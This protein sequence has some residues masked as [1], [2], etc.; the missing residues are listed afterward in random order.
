MHAIAEDLRYAA[1]S[2]TKRP[3]YA[4]VTITVLALAIGANTTVFSVFN[5][6]FLRPLPYPDGDRLVSVYNTYPGLG[7][8]IAGTSIP[9]YL[10]RRAEAPSL[11]DLAIV[12]RSARS[13]TGEGPAEQIAVAMA[14]PSLFSVL[15][16]APELGRS[17]SDDEAVPG[18]D[19]VAVLS[20]ALWLSRFGA[21]ANV[22][23]QSIRLDGRP[24]RIVG[25]MPPA[26]GYPDR[27][28]GVWVPFAF[29]PEQMSDAER[30][31]EFSTSVG[32][33]APGA[34]VAGL[35]AE[36]AAIVRRTN[37]RLRER[38]PF[39][40]S[41]GFTGRS[42]LL[43]D[44]IVGDLETMLLVLEGIVLAVLLIASANVTNLQLARMASRRKELS[45]RAALGAD[46]ARLVRLVVIESLTLAAV[47]GVV[48]TGLAMAGLELVRALGLDLSPLGFDFELDARVLLFT[49]GAALLAAC[50]SAA[51]PVV[52]LV[53]D[54]LIRA[55]HEA[56][57]L[58]SGGRSSQAFRG[59][60]VIVQIAV[61][62]ALLVA[63]GMLTKSFYHLQNT[64]AGFDT[65]NVWTARIALPLGR[66][67]DDQA[68]ARFYTQALET[69]GTL[70][71]VTEA[72][73]TSSLPFSG[74]NSQGSITVAGYE[75]PAGGLP[76][77]VQTRSINEAYFPA[78]RVPVV[79]GRNFT[80]TEREPVVIVD[81]NMARKYWPDG[82][83]LGQ[84][85][86][87]DQPYTIVGV[88]PAIK[89][90]TLADEALK[91]TVYWHYAQRPSSAGVLAL[92]SSV[93]PEQLTRLVGDTLRGIDPDV[94][95]FNI[96]SLDARVVGS[97]GPQRAPMVLTLLFAAGSFVLAVVGIYGVLTWA[98]TQRFGEIGVRIA[99][100]ARAS[101]ITTMI[102]RQG[103]KLTATGMALGLALAL[104]LGRVLASQIYA[105]APLDPTVFGTVLAG[106]TGAAL[107]ASWLPARRAS[108][109]DPMRVLRQE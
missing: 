7:L 97:L 32:R 62:A 53:R 30:G 21:A 23:G 69:L 16:I 19:D 93:P 59:I 96:M 1:R 56:G 101:D 66:Y 33:L 45:V 73:F 76:P 26:F 15:G 107:L 80:A 84:R 24:F 50:L 64:S 57:R 17:F 99:L 77:H 10:D 55:V 13:L 92:R 63:A 100:G 35:N 95:L 34:T 31:Q 102:L 104:V 49:A 25:V 85:I 11:E 42:E 3:L 87:L 60:L 38:A 90:E 12:T 81:E 74:N 6:L 20:H 51:L 65:A 29:T 36:L 27:N 94:P 88:V 75:V 79:E 28:T 39:I 91:E 48:G 8:E 43:R 78:L 70:P 4:L 82:D 52:M 40:E 109:I 67:A 105:A 106:L 86:V 58:G 89:H 47:G 41:T 9:D 22:I 54:D 2:F 71:G 61:S 108:R 72:G 46:R 37:E 98:V 14:S 18:A 68:Q 5:G 44:A 83:A 103:G